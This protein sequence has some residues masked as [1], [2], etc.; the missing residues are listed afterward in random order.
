MIRTYAALITLL[1]EKA[2]RRAHYERCRESYLARARKR[3]TEK[4]ELCL[5]QQREYGQRNREVLLQR[6]KAYGKRSRPRL[7][8]YRRK[9]FVAKYSIDPQFKI[10]HLLRSRVDQALRGRVQSKHTLELLGCG[11]ADLK[12]HLE[13]Q[14]QPG[15]TWENQ[16]EWHIDHIRPCASFDLTNPAQQESCFNY[17]NLQPLWAEGNLKKGA[18][19]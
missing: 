10:V 19:Y 15:M 14:F 2:R 3:Y 7:R 4:K 6:K 11:I 9:Y 13:K 16:G 5:V 18:S 8:I 12:A 17:T 1:K